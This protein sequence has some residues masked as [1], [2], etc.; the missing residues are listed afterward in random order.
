MTPF[1]KLATADE[2]LN[3]VQENIRMALDP[4]ST[5]IIFSRQELTGTATAAGTTFFHN[6]KR[7]PKGWLIIDKENAGDV[8]RISWSTTSITLKTS[9]ATTIIKFWLF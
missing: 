9:A 3:R 8:Y 6:L 7:Q 4:I 1:N 5:D 2:L